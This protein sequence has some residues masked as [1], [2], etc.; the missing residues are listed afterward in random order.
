LS[1]RL[2]G[3][4]ELLRPHN[5][6]VAALTTLIGYVVAC[7]AGH[8]CPWQP[9]LYAA[10]AVALVAAGGY[11]INDYYDVEAD[12][13]SKP[14]RPIPSGRVGR[15]EALLLAL[16][17]FLAGFAVSLPLGPVAAFFVAVNILSVY[18]YSW[19]AKKTGFVGN[20]VVALNSAAT[21][22]MGALA[23]CAYTGVECPLVA[24]VPAGIAFGLVLGREV[25]KG[26]EDYHGDKVKCYMTLAV[27]WGPVRAARTAAVLLAAVI[28]LSPL[29][30]AAGY[31]ILYLVLAAATD[32][33]IAYSIAVLLRVSDDEEAIEASRKL[34]SVLKVGFLLGALAFILGA[35]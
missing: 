3:Y 5:L 23:C 6:L 27:R 10:L 14:W 32:A 13:V 7:R 11:V 17:L 29:P 24:L 20:V 8:V 28:A 21:I 9:Y 1:G 33:A 35:L 12:A 19:Y 15:R 26:I 2:K 34:R 25:V 22:L 16:F 4:V 30:L 31:G 18:A